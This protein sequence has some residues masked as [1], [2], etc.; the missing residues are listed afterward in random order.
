MLVPL[1]GTGFC[2]SLIRSTPSDKEPVMPSRPSPVQP[3]AIL[4]A[5]GV[6]LSA[7][8][9]YAQSDSVV[10]IEI[11][12]PVLMPG[13]STTVRLWAGFDSG[14]DFA[15]GRIATDLLAD[16]G[17]VDIAGAWSDVDLIP[18]MDWIATTPGVPEAGGYSGVVA[19]QWHWWQMPF[20]TDTSDPIAFWEA[21]FTA[22][23]D[24]GAFIVDLSTMTI[25]FDVYFGAYSS[26]TESRLDGL[27][28]GAGRITVVPAPASGL[29]LLGVLAMRRRR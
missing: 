23:T 22:P 5:A 28:E 21:T 19:G 7:G 2:G 24:S 16:S 9:A 3:T 11:D 6:A 26:G 4:A 8:L 27:T 25:L 29:V 14:R 13:E 20:E 12:R 18:P 17:G 1:H 15:M 10:S